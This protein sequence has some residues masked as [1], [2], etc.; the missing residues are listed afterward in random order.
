MALWG[1][2]T[3]GHLSRN[4][5]AWFNP[6]MDWTDMAWQRFTQATSGG[7]FG[8]LWLYGPISYATPYVWLGTAANSTELVLEWFDGTDWQDTAPLDMGTSWFHRAVR[9]TAETMMMDLVINGATVATFPADLSS[10]PAQST[11]YLLNEGA[12]DDV[13][14]MAFH[15]RYQSALSDAFIAAQMASPTFFRSHGLIAWAELTVPTDLTDRFGH[16]WASAATVTY[17]DGPFTGQWELGRMDFATSM[18]ETS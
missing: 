2:A 14:G 9:Y 3:F 8:T 6:A 10:F 17:L 1:S 12:S 18:Q 16:D 13:L 7:L 15:A 4:P 5:S 11:E